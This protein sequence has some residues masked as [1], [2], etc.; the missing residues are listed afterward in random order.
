[1]PRLYLP[2]EY[3]SVIEKAL[4]CSFTIIKSNGRLSTHPMIPLYDRP[5]GKIYL[6]SSLLFTKKVEEVKRNNRVGLYFY[7]RS[8]TGGMYD[9]EVFVKGDV[10]VLEDNVHRGWEKLLP[11]WTVKEPYIPAFMRQ[12]LALPLFWE[13][14]IL[15]VTPRKIYA[16]RDGDNSKPPEVF[17]VSQ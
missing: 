8:W 10:K 13:R 7:N 11:L 5:S 6:T 14:V 15:E 1:V 4:V 12:R 3:E 17:E 16:W 9:H 2:D